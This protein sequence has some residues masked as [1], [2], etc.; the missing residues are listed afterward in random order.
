[1]SH[2]GAV[3]SHESDGGRQPIVYASMTLSAQELN[4]NELECLAVLFGTEKFRKYIKHQ[5]FILEMDS[6]AHSWLL[7]LPRQLGKT[8]RWA[9]KMSALKFQVRHIRE[10]QNIV[11]DTL[12]R[13]FDSSFA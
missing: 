2:W 11:A 9:V 8:G 6:Q 5:E 7:S 4:L 12:S 3:L 10:T 13:M 1:M